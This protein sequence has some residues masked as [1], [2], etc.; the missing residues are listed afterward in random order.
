MQTW[1]TSERKDTF[2]YVGLLLLALSVV[3][4]LLA[5]NPEVS[6]TLGVL[7]DLGAIFLSTLGFFSVAV[8]PVWRAYKSRSPS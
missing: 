6:V 5:E 2:L 4:G 3:F 7:L 8:N 1:N